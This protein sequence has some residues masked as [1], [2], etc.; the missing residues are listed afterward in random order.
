MIT[1]STLPNAPKDAES[2]REALT[3]LNRAVKQIEEQLVYVRRDIAERPNELEVTFVELSQELAH[4]N[5][6][7]GNVLV[8]IREVEAAIERFERPT[9]CPECGRKFPNT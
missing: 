9:C 8:R 2:A 5:G 3:V 1:L 4:L 6:L 7:L